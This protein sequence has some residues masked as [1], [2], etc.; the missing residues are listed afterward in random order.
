MYRM[1]RGPPSALC[2]TM[3]A[4]SVGGV[5]GAMLPFGGATPK[6]VTFSSA[7]FVLDWSPCSLAAGRSP[8][9]LGSTSAKTCGA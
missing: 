8:F 3:P 7:A 6:V 2:S 9:S 1:R 4:R 5:I